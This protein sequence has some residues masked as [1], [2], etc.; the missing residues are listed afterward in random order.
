MPWLTWG[1]V[2][3]RYKALLEAIKSD[4]PPPRDFQMRYSNSYL[5]QMAKWAGK[6]SQFISMGITDA[7]AVE[8]KYEA[9]L[10]E[11]GNP[12]PESH[13]PYLDKGDSPCG[14]C[15]WQNTCWSGLG[16]PMTPA[17]PVEQF[18]AAKRPKPPAATKVPQARSDKEIF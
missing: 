12:S 9:S 6:G 16:N 1:K 15:N 7:K 13:T 2:K 18:E 10:T 4:V 8:R 17:V 3:S 5:L 14:W 11:K